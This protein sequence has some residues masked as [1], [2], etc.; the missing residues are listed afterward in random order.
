M[1]KD[2]ARRGGQKSRVKVR[3]L[4]FWGWARGNVWLCGWRML[5]AGKV[6]AAPFSQS[7][8]YG[9]QHENNSP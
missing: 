2:G 7:F 8:R 4:C 6:S 1:Q 3:L 9:D 5:L